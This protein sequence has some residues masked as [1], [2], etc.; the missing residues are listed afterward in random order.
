MGSNKYTLALVTLAVVWLQATST[1]LLAQQDGFTPQQLEH[2]ENKVRPILVERCYECHADGESEGGLSLQ[3]R[4]AMIVGGDAGAAIVPGDPEN[5]LLIQAIHY[6][7]VYEMPPDSKMPDEEIKILEDWI[8]DTAPWPKHSDVEIETA[9]SFDIEA[10]AKDHWCWQPVTPPQLPDGVAGS[11]AIDFLIESKLKEKG[12]NPNGPAKRSSLL[13]RVCFDL[14]GLPP[15]QELTQQFVIEQSV[16][17]EQIIDPLLES[18]HFG[19]RWA[20]HWMDL[21]RYAE[22]H[23]HEFDY[24]IADAWKYRDY[25]IRAFNADVPY[26]QFVT[27]HLAGD[28]LESPRRN[29]DSDFDESVLATGF[30]FLGEATHGPVDSKADE[31]A[32]VDNQID[33]MCRSFVGLTVACARC[34]DHKFDAISTQDYYALSG[35]LQSSRKYRAVVDKDRV[36]ENAAR[37]VAPIRHRFATLTEAFRDSLANTDVDVAANRLQVVLSGD[38][39][40]KKEKLSQAIASA[41]VL[42]RHPEYVEVDLDAIDPEVISNTEVPL[43]P[44]YWKTEGQAFANA[45]PSMIVGESLQW[46]HPN[47]ISSAGNGMKFA[48]MAHSSTFEI[49]HKFIHVRIKAKKARVELVVDGCRMLEHNAIL[50]NGLIHKDVNHDEYQWLTIGKEL[51]LHLGSRAWLEFTD[52]GDGYFAVDRVVISPDGRP[53]QE[54]P[55]E[56]AVTWKDRTDGD[57][58]SRAKETFALVKDAMH[59]PHAEEVMSWVLE[60]GLDE[61]LVGGPV[62]TGIRDC[63][64]SIVDINNKLPRPSKALAI[65]D[66]F[67][68]NEH[69]FVRGNHKMLGKVA[70][71]QF[72]TAIVD[73]DSGFD[74]ESGSGRLRLANQIVDP[75]NPLTSR[76]IVNRVWHHLFGRGIVRSVD[77]FGVLGDEPSHPELL[78]HLADGF[79]E[80]GWSIKRL[81]KKILLTDAYQRSSTPSESGQ[82]L[83]PD[84]VYLSRTNVRRLQG[85]AI[86]DSMLAASGRLDKKMYGP[87]VRIHVTSFMQGRGRPGKSGPIDGEGR[88][89]IYIETRRNFLSPMMLAFD[90]PIPFNAIGLRT[91]SNVPAQALILMNDPFVLQ[92]AE[93]FAGKALQSAD[94][95]DGRIE[96]VYLSAMARKPIESELEKAK[97]FITTHANRLDADVDSPEVW[98]DFCHVVFNTKEFIY[99]N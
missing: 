90:T 35:F 23:G 1:D 42:N 27:E 74:R 15:T 76:V 70:P 73:E 49:K 9:K 25:L 14:T 21:S 19:E 54:D 22:T 89:S 44:R 3:S 59:G 43:D 95:V 39:D 28:L 5:S 26:D 61:V 75:S 72:L 62:G 24:P 45:G 6:G 68:E 97:T 29:P 66:G 4:N 88:R 10:R 63:R 86:R 50:F 56:A 83:D 79:V 20:R 40:A 36:F 67:P 82:E 58:L 31:S 87:S 60:S 85:E 16:S 33:V 30:W 77:N 48:G 2:F 32:R 41:P 99:L 57:P 38:D 11:A 47:T 17:L 53:P 34:H 37:K 69:V 13:R 65:T 46:P 92:Q 96:F 7:D 91:V 98:K 8:R 12:L 51:Y 94:D 18:P 55:A 80:N 84:N 93:K 64:Q 81:V 52:P 78:D 71:R